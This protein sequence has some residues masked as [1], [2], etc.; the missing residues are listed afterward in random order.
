[1]T[2][3]TKMN[4][5]PIEHIAAYGSVASGKSTLLRRFSR[6]CKRE[7]IIYNPTIAPMDWNDGWR[8]D[9]SGFFSF[10]AAELRTADYSDADDFIRNGLRANDADIFCD[11][12]ADCFAVP[13][14]AAHQIVTKGRHRGLRIFLA[15]QRPN[16]IAPTVRA[17][18]TILYCFRLAYTDLDSVLRDAGFSPKQI[19]CKLPAAAGECITVDAIDG[20]IHSGFVDVAGILRQ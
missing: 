15:S 5:P 17:Q 16:Q 2:K 14:K 1:M 3:L 6:H 4:R 18:C 20:R 19:E 10:G 11:E 8:P 9:R 13:Q 12:G 7:Q